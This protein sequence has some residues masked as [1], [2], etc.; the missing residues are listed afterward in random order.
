MSQNSKNG[1]TGDRGPTYDWLSS[2]KRSAEL[3]M[4]V[5]EEQIALWQR[6]VEEMSSVSYGIRSLTRDLSEV[7][8]RSTGY[9]LDLTSILTGSGDA[10]A[11]PEGES[12]VP[13]TPPQETEPKSQDED[14]ILG[15][16]EAARKQVQDLEVKLEVTD[17]T[18]G[19]LR[20]DLDS[21]TTS[22]ASSKK[23]LDAVKGR[24]E[25][26]ETELAGAQDELKEANA[27]ID[28][29]K[30]RL[31]NETDR[32]GSLERELATAK[33]ELDA[34]LETIGSIE[35]QLR[36]LPEPDGKGVVRVW[37]RHP[38]GRQTRPFKIVLEACV[39]PEGRV[40]GV[41]ATSSKNPNYTKQAIEGVV[42]DQG[43]WRRVVVWFTKD[44]EPHL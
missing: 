35:A 10:G 21:A 23:E 29:L 14:E 31:Q 2:L 3:N 40:L 26:S 9:W 43:E 39:G 44:G 8:E 24:A 15:K 41:R 13:P 20:R 18:I 17:D 30:T 32:A 4:K 36:A 7:G 27:A 16:L 38:D 22:V 28:E 6:A 5:C 33:T 12:T 25:A 42:G 11:G 34:A 19:S 1:E 37:R